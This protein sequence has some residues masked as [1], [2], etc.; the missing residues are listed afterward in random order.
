MSFSVSTEQQIAETLAKETGLVCVDPD[1][2]WVDPELIRRLPRSFAERHKVLPLH[3]NRDGEVVVVMAEPRDPALLSELESS[4]G[5]RIRATVA[6]ESV[7][8]HAIYRHYDLAPMARDLLRGA[9]PAHASR[10]SAALELDP[11]LVASR[12]R[13]GGTQPYVELYNYMLV[14]AI[15]RRAS[16]IHVEPEAERLRVRLR[17]DGLLREALDLPTWAAAPLASRIKGLAAMDIADTRRPQDGKT[18]VKL[19]SR[20]IDLRVATMPGKYGEKLVVRLLDPAMTRT[21]LGRLGWQTESLSA[22]YRMVSRPQGLV[23][24]VG[25]TGSGKS[26]TLYATIQRLNS[27]NTAIVTIEDPIE[28]EV[29]GI[30]QVQ[31]NPKAEVTFASAIRA[32]LRQD[33]NVM[34]I[35]EVRDEETAKA[36]VNAANTGHL[37]LSTLHTVNALGAIQRMIDL[38]VPPFM[39]GATLSG[40][41]A[42]RLLRRVCPHCSI[43][44]APSAEDWKHL[45]LPAFSLGDQVRRVGPGCPSCQY[46]GYRGRVGVFELVTITDAMRALLIDGFDS[47]QLFEQAR[48]DGMVTLLEDALEKVRQGLTTLEELARA[49]PIETRSID[50][51]R[52]SE[53]EP[54]TED[55]P[56]IP[57][58]AALTAQ[59]PPVASEPG[60]PP[61]ILIVDDAEE[62]LSMVEMALSDDYRV[63]KARDGVQALAEVRQTRP[64][65]VVLDVMMPR[66]SGYEVCAQLK[67]DPATESLP[68][69]MLSARGETA[70]IKQGLR[71]GADD[72]L[73]KPFDPEELLLRIRALLRR[74]GR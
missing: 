28:Y 18:S 49:V 38:D 48:A 4:L 13:G 69:I 27:E 44:D 39:L 20:P 22:Y 73:P 41:V 12:L 42:Q 10:A 46:A 68:V 56:A 30:T 23:L 53:P 57:A 7:I 70:H 43:V 51:D 14:N 58:P 52:F 3:R 66:L 25:P 5:G 34:V 9:R 16:D 61:E 32:V 15:E 54:D 71:A 29:P 31:V 19:G 59:P 26:T 65:L 60:L 74:A 64:D 55:S 17:I 8:A 37:V 2:E 33:P 21:D 36:C 1:D 11:N 6:P 72:Y 67:A 24:V 63:R 40:V 45:G 47:Q 62:I 50:A 35:G